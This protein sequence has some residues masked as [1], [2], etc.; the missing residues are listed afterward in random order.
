MLRL[1]KS[2]ACDSSSSLEP[3]SLPAESAW[4][5]EPCIC[6]VFFSQWPILAADALEHL[7]QLVLTRRPPCCGAS[8][9]FLPSA[10]W[11]SRKNWHSLHAPYRMEAYFV[12]WHSQHASAACLR[13]VVPY[14][15]FPTVLCW[16]KSSLTHTKHSARLCQFCR[17]YFVHA[18]PGA[19]LLQFA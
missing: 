19:A 3:S 17:D 15:S 10:K 13:R 14:A 6:S 16:L 2:F 7:L 5:H 18:W 4:S 8:Q 1:G 12:L 9:F 11:L